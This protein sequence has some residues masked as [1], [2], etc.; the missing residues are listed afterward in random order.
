MQ[1]QIAV[2][3]VEDTQVSGVLLVEQFL[4]NYEF[5]KNVV[6]NK[7]EVRVRE[8]AD[9]PFQPLTKEVENRILLHAQQS[10]TLGRKMHSFKSKDAQLHTKRNSQLRSWKESL[11]VRSCTNKSGFSAYDN[12]QFRR[13]KTANCRVFARF[14]ATLTV[15][16]NNN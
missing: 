15:K 7:L 6:T 13:E 9:S 5:R 14:F 1:E 16:A 12:S 11:I 10:A 3:P 8:D 2:S 4:E